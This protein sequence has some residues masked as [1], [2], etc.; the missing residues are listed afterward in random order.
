MMDFS[1]L[2]DQLTA[3]QSLFWVATLLLALGSACLAASLLM[4]IRKVRS[5]AQERRAD[6]QGEAAVSGSSENRAAPD[7]P[8]G[9][10]DRPALRGEEPS[11]AILLRRLQTAGD[12]LEDIAGDLEVLTAQPDESNL[13]HGLPGV[14]YVF[15][16][17]G[18]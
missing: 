14:D 10:L 5:S 8:A 6:V 17:K 1:S 15:K 16:A 12:R 9:I 4:V 18:A 11:L 7:I 13:K 2:M 3:R